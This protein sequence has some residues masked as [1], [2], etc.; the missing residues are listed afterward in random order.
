M[1]NETVIR[2][3]TEGFAGMRK[4]GVLAAEVLDMIT[5]YVTAGVSTKLLDQLCHDYILANGAIPSL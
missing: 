5:P 3:G 1:H 2:H 4:A